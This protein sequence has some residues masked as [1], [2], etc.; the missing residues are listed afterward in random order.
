MKHHLFYILLVLSLFKC[1]SE[2]LEPDTNRVGFDYFPLIVGDSLIYDVEE[3]DFDIVGVVDTSQ[4]LLKSVVADSFLSQSGDVT[5]IIHRY[6]KEFV[7]D[8]WQF[9]TAWSSYRNSNQAVVVEENVP[10]LKITFP[11]ETEKSWD[12]NRLNTSEEDIYTLDSVGFEY[13]G[14]EIFDNTITVVQNNN[15]DS[16]IQLDRRAEIYASGV[17]LI[18]KEDVLLNYCADPSCIGQQEIEDGR[19]FIQK[20]RSETN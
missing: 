9:I 13:I 18:Y 16:L 12:G 3:I 15:Q 19:I 1:S 2:N 4:Y 11:L 10:F 6:E 8:P 5:Y 17:G 14:E 20:V 7:G